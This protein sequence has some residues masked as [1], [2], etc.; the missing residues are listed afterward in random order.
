MSTERR[1]R[2]IASIKTPEELRSY[3][4]ELGIDLNC[5]DA[6]L[7][8]DESP[9]TE[10]LQVYGR[11]IGNRWAVHPMEGWDGTAEGGI[12]ESVVRRWTRFGHSGA[13][14]I[15]GGEAMAVRLDGRANPNQ[16]VIN[17]RNQAGLARLREHL[18]AAHK[19]KYGRTDDML[20]GFQLTHSGRFCRPRDKKRLE[21]WIVYRHP[22]LD[23][24]F[25]ID[26]DDRILTDDDVRRLVDDFVRAARVARNAGADFIDIKNCHGYLLH[27]FLSAYT[28][29]GP[30]GGSF[31]NRTRLLREIVQ[32][33]RGEVPGLL[34]GVR[35]SAFDTV[36]FVPDPT[37]SRDG[38][39]GPGIPEDFSHCLPYRYGFGVNQLNP[40]EYDLADTVRFLDLLESLA[41]CR[42][43]SPDSLSVDQA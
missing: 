15:W 28:R 40:V 24:R 39:V 35:V 10:P 37:R 6:I 7:T 31:E 22:I 8:G 2:R 23:A 26:S 38:G 14:L 32:A 36:P 33:I 3:A 13:K 4:R 25:G 1:F 9:L 12:T 20:I 18:L 16:L 5:D 17:E 34:I 43:G 41:A 21:P 19:D 27:E 30:Y 42:R 11:P 29:P